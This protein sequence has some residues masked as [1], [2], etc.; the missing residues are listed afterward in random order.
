MKSGV[1]KWV[2]KKIKIGLQNE[3]ISYL[4]YESKKCSWGVG[5]IHTE[6]DEKEEDQTPGWFFV[7][8][9]II[10]GHQTHDHH[11]RRHYIWCCHCH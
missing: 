4:A 6:K 2:C 3:N 5:D 8:T 11:C 7:D 10:L 1:N 9:I